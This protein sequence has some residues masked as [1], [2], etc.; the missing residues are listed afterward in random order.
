MQGLADG[1]PSSLLSR[2]QGVAVEITD[3]ADVLGAEISLQ[4]FDEVVPYE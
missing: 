3:G 2:N 4:I 1:G